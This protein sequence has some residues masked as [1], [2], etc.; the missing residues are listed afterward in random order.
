V[1]LEFREYQVRKIVNIHKHV[2]GPWFWDKY[3]AHPYV[4]C[5]SGC[6]FCYSRGGFYLGKRD[7]TTFDTLLQVKSNAVELLR[8]ELPRL[9]KDVIACGDWQQPAEDRYRLSRQMLEV[10][11]EHSFPLFV[12]ERSPL[13]VRDL[14]LLA[15]INQHAWAG[16]AFSLSNLDPT[17]KQAFEPRS[18]GV[19]R[20]LK[21]MEKLAAAGIL[22]GVSL[23]PVIPFA[24]DDRAQ[25]EQVIRAIKDCGGRFVLVGGLSM[26]G[27]QAEYTLAAAMR[28]DP[29]LA[30]HMRQLYRW[31]PGGKPNY[32]PPH[33]YSSKLGLLVRELCAAHPCQTGSHAISPRT[34]RRSI[35]GS[36]SDCF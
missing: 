16:V 36:L 34:L 22:T 28:F 35:R 24:G 32:S 6:E 15:E 23:M 14:D 10:V 9:Q 8:K 3:S 30:T 19:K 13:I 1:N 20:R 29:A 27:V 25:L 2:D 31:Q 17:L 18:P 12:I 33:A 21:A 5:R 7:P 4:G 26:D 11:C